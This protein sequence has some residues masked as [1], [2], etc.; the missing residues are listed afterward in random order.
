MSIYHVH[1]STAVKL[2]ESYDGVMPFAN[3]LKHFFSF[4]K[5]Y[6]SRDRK[7]IASFCY[8]YFRM[9]DAVNAVSTQERILIGH[10]LCSFEPSEMMEKLKPDWN[11]NIHL[12]QNQKV[13]LISDFF[14]PEILFRYRHFLC[15]GVD[16]QNLSISYLSQPDLFIRIRPKNRIGT[17]NKL[18]KYLPDYILTN[19]DCVRLD[20]TTKV[21][22]FFTIDKEVVI[23]DFNSQ[24]VLDYFK[25]QNA[26]YKTPL[27]TVWD[28]CAASGGKSILINDI[29]NAR[30]ELTVSDIRPSIIFNLHKRFNKAGIKNY[31]YF[32]ADIS[33]ESFSYPLPPQQIIICDVPCSGS[34]T[35]SRTPE[36]LLHFDEKLILQYQN[37]QKKIVE[38]VLPYLAKNGFLVYITCSVFKQENDEVVEFLTKEFSLQVVSKKVLSG[39]SEKADSMFVA[40]LQKVTA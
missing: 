26:D 19:E 25:P 18:E 30:I 35:W 21:E 29:F 28:C 40:I 5:K 36:Q 24:K 7:N 3:Y 11:R 27:T 31:N 39:D 34:G 38:N 16:S 4:N 33:S 37:T 14:N 20:S 8:Q 32:I 9:G 12:N 23:Q 6:G 17:L 22:E 10:F 15:D 1:L 2:I 13:K